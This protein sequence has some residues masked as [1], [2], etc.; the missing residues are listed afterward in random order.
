MSMSRRD[1]EC[2]SSFQTITGLR[3]IKPCGSAR[4]REANYDEDRPGRINGKGSG[5][6]VLNRYQ[7]KF[8]VQC[9]HKRSMTQSRK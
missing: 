7:R 6:N 4:P 9:N 2:R 8:G 5:S 3:V 1:R